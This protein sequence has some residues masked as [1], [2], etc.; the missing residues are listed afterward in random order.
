MESFVEDLLS[1]GLMREGILTLS[2]QSFDPSDV[3]T[4]ILETFSIKAEAKRIQISHHNYRS[5]KDPSSS[6]ET[7]WD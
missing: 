2:K 7:M 6:E 4:F 5:I 1:L 3:F